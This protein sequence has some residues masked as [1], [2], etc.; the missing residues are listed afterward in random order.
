MA[1]CIDDAVTIVLTT[2]PYVIAY[3]QY[4]SITF[5]G[6]LIG[7]EDG[8]SYI[9]KMLRG[10]EGDWLFRSPYT[11]YPQK[12]IIAF[13]PYLLLGKLAAKP[14]QHEQLVCLFHL[15]RMA[16]II[17]YVLTTHSFVQ[18]FLKNKH[19]IRLAVVLITLG[20][21]IGY[22]FLVIPSFF[23]YQAPLE[24]Y[25]SETFGFLSL[26]A[27]PHLAFSR[28][29]VLL[30]LKY[31]ILSFDHLPSS[32]SLVKSGCYLFLVGFFQPLS[33]VSVWMVTGGY[34]LVRLI[35]ELK[36]RQTY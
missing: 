33:I 29:F 21:G 9:A 15:F 1:S 18:I 2:L 35:Y 11:G 24:F 5:T 6:F 19:N 36:K 14:G 12:G 27:L 34:S 20:E 30:S 26:Y 17:F 23:K 28:S 16:G 32:T 3:S 4:H 25:S 8:N 22:L 13:L 31:F 10:A 7:T